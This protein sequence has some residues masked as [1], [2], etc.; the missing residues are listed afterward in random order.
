MKRLTIGIL[1]HVDAGKTTLSEALLR[2]HGHL[3]VPKASF[4]L[5]SHAAIVNVIGKRVE[6][7]GHEHGD[8]LPC[9]GYPAQCEMLHVEALEHDDTHDRL[10][11]V[12]QQES[13]D[14]KH[15]L[16]LDV[17]LGLEHPGAIPDEAV[18]HAQNI[19]HRI[20]QHVGHTQ[21]RV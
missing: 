20:A 15:R 16:A 3:Q 5:K 10:Q 14:K 8:I 1:A 2:R 4:L 9:L 17:A 19:A 7:H 13:H 11:P 21:Q 18:D 12:A 6:Y